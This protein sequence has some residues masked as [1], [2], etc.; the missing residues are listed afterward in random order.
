[1]TNRIE[2]DIRERSLF[3]D[4]HIFGE[5]GA[6]ERLKGRARFAVDPSAPAQA[7]VVDIEN[8]P[9][10]ADGMVEFAADILV[11]KPVD[12]ARGNRRLFF[13]Y[14]NRANV[15]ALQFFCDAPF[16]DDPTAL[17]HA[18]NGFFFGRG[19]TVVWC[20]WQGDALP[21]DGRFL[22]DVPVASEDGQPITGT[23]RTEFIV[24]QA[25]IVTLSLSGFASTRSHPPLSRE[26]RRAT[27]TRRRYPGDPREPVPAEAWAFARVETGPSMGGQRMEQ[28][29][30]PSDTT[31]HM[32][33]GFEPGYIYEL[34]YEARDPLVLGLGY[35][36]VRDFIGFLKYEDADA[37]GRANPLRE[38]NGPGVEKAYC[39]GRSQAGRMIR[40]TLYQGFNA[41]VAGRKVFD[42]ALSHVAGAGRMIL[43]HRF[44]CGTDAAGQEFEAHDKAADCFPFAYAECTDHLTGRRDA[45]LR[46]PETDPLVI[47]T[48]TSTEYW[49]R[50]GSLVHTD[51][52]GNDLNPPEN[53]RV[54][55]WS[56]TQHFADPSFIPPSKGGMAHFTNRAQTSMLFRAMLVALDAWATDGTAPPESRIP[57]RADGTLV[58]AREWRARFPTIPGAQVP[59]GPAPLE[60]L[61]FGDRI[62]DGII[63]KHPPAMVDAEGYGVFVSAP[64]ADGN[65]LGGVT[66]PMVV[67]PLG[68]FTGWNI[69]SREAAGSGAM[70]WFD[71][72]YL[73]FSETP[74]ERAQTGDPRPS[75][76]ERYGSNED[77]AAAV[78][79][80]CRDLVTQR[81]MLEED[82]DRVVAQAR[83]WF[84]PWTVVRLL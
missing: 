22:L 23:V 60:L 66:A 70:S 83:D 24:E 82:V 21:G 40:E 31:I 52:L 42:G 39:W 74:S 8:T 81:L 45:V 5:A 77:Y 19:Y 34:I 62:A 68:T 55:L 4:G 48:Q 49:Q 84:R 50:R 38:D 72:S 26:T 15:R 69:R 3:A 11:L 36:S 28:G 46:H 80:A 78:E 2:L 47:H 76:L 1:M 64:D 25:G 30:I 9:V 43:N 63:D 75:I 13:D 59:K 10:N 41:D 12:M 32:P 58:T 79:A 14:G 71:G 44:A 37:A 67:A 57:R 53:V 65:D 33:G 51:T 6:Y 18:G 56:S 20:A 54:Y 17:D 7:K 35:V 73:P 61:H 29:L 16:S 27:L